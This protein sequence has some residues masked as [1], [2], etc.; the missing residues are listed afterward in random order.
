MYT[1]YHCHICILCVFM[2]SL[3][4]VGIRRACVLDP[5]SM[6]L[7]ACQMCWRRKRSR[8]N[9]I[10]SRSKASTVSFILCNAFIVLLQCINILVLVSMTGYCLSQVKQLPKWQLL[11]IDV[12]VTE[13]FESVDKWLP[14]LAL[15]L[16][17]L[18]LI[19]MHFQSRAVLPA[20]NFIRTVFHLRSHCAFILIWRLW[21]N[22]RNDWLH[23]V[24]SP[25]KR[26]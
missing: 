13:R 21:L 8:Q 23:P 16:F 6:Q 17:I 4:V 2:D 3:I 15:S 22:A 20:S 7:S 19:C 10:D 14:P 11:A 9:D 25:C 1:K 5:R 26:T 24:L 18:L 12:I